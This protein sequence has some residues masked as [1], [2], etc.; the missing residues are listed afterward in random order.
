LAAYCRDKSDYED[1]LRWCEQYAPREKQKPDAE[2]SSGQ[3]ETGFVYLM[4]SGRFYKIGRSNSAGRRDYELGIQLR[5][6]AKTV[7]VLRTD[8]PVGIEAYWHRRFEAKRKNGEWFELDAAD[9]KAFKR[10]K[11]M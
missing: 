1:V 2:G 11:F 8:D 7:H 10:R 3:E 5:E 6:P 9:V 4:R